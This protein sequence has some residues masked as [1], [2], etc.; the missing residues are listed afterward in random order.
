M[1]TAP[2]HGAAPLVSV[3]IPVLNGEAYLDEA[4][5]SIPADAGGRVETIVV[6]DG[7]TD[8]TAELV[9]RHRGVRYF[10]QVK[11]GIGAAR[12]AGLSLAGG[13][14]IAFLDADDYWL[15]G[16]LCLQLAVLRAQPRTDMVFGHIRQ[17][18]SPELSQSE[19][20]RIRC[21]DGA[22]PAE[23][24]STMLCRRAV[25]DR[26]GLFETRW[27]VGQDVDWIM[28][29]RACGLRSVM[30]A[31][32]VYMRRLHTKNNGNTRSEDFGDRLKIIKAMLDRRRAQATASDAGG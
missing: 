8:G 19:R 16:K 32:T 22:M 23:L 20:E 21:P 24:P 9:R 6:D 2:P 18:H 10:Y 28:R 12:N 31:E 3:I 17:F 15:P 14:F 4:L 1:A 13:A 11:A 26:V 25:F 29:A 27:K 30:L 5:A 7:S